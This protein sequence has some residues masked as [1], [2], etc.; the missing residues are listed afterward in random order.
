MVK[1]V[2]TAAHVIVGVVV[3][4]V[5]LL[6]VLPSLCFPSPGRNIAFLV[7]RYLVTTG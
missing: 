4:V 2:V 7:I 3:V 5:T 6:C 1:S